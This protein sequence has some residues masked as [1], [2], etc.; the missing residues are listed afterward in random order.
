M[1]LIQQA[2]CIDDIDPEAIHTYQNLEREIEELTRQIEDFEK[3]S[4]RRTGIIVKRL[5]HISAF[6]V[7]IQ[8]DYRS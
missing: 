5:L 4:E 7:N 3:A 8:Y 2:G 6:C 1:Q